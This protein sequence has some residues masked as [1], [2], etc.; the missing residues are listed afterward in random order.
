MF[1]QLKINMDD[2]YSIMNAIRQNTAQ[3]IDGKN[4]R[5][6]IKLDRHNI[7]VYRVNDVTRIDIKPTT[8]E[9]SK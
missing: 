4:R 5:I 2:Y 3:V 8:R 7:S 1:T 9:A 6:D